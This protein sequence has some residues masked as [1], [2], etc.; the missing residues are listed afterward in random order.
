MTRMISDMEMALN[1]LGDPF[2]RPEVRPEAVPSGAPQ[3]HFR[4]QSE[5]SRLEPGPA[6]RAG[7]GPEPIVSEPPVRIPPF[8]DGSGA[9][10]HES[11]HLA[12]STS[13]VQEVD[14]SSSSGL[15]F[16][17][18]PCWLHAYETAPTVAFTA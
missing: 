11:R 3:E 4:E 10:A 12:D 18:G 8:D 9:G 5:L 1:D 2:Q 14:R 7:L 16:D 6:P 17:L 13:P 15:P